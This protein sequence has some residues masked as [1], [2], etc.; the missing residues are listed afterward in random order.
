MSFE[1]PITILRG[2]QT[3]FSII[4]LGT[5][6]RSANVF[7]GLDEYYDGIDFVS[8]KIPVPAQIDY[9]LFCAVWS[10][11]V[12]ICLRLVARF[13]AI[14]S[15]PVVV[16]VLDGLT[17]IFWFA[18]A[19]ALAVFTSVFSF[20]TLQACVAFSFFAWAAFLATFLLD[21]LPIIK[22]AAGRNN[23]MIPQ[24]AELQQTA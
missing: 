8:I 2:L 10:I 1:L 20:G 5:A 19:I 17:M 18:G 23:G 22:G 12:V 15:H 11:L 9:I 7:S 4:V 21:L 13:V 16:T 3:I 24:T 6:A 14:I